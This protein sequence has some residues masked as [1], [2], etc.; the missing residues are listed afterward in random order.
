MAT[1]VLEW[2]NEFSLLAPAASTQVSKVIAGTLFA[3]GCTL[4]RILLRVSLSPVTVDTIVVAHMA[5]WSGPSGSL[6]A[7]IS[8]DNNDSYLLW[9][10]HPITLE[11][12]SGAGEGEPRYSRF[13]FDLRGQRKARQDN[14]TIVF[15]VCPDAASSVNCWVST[16]VLCLLQ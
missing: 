4:Q 11:S 3:K 6:P 10:S 7:D 14:D 12:V 8:G 9:E 13:N 5:V 16:R 1:R 2:R 15:A